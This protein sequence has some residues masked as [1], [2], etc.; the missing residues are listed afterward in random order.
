M[1]SH[2]LSFTAVPGAHYTGKPQQTN[3]VDLPELPA[4]EK[5]LCLCCA[6]STGTFHQTVA[7]EPNEESS[8]ECEQCSEDD[9]ESSELFTQAFAVKGS[10]YEKNYQSN[11]KTVQSVIRSQQEIVVNL[12]P[13][14]DNPKDTN[15]IRVVVSVQDQ[16]L[17]IGYIG[18]RKIPKVTSAIQKSDIVSVRVKSVTS[19]FVKNLN[20]RKLRAFVQIC[21]KGR[22]LPDS[23]NNTYNSVL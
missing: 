16:S 5:S 20:A 22:W 15:A 6:Q 23:N 9:G 17:P 18:V 11:L 10:T 8:D 2:G 21:K 4:I 14:R 3:A 7:S 13:E 12:V 1:G 19:W